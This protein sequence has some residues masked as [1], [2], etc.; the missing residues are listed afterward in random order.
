MTDVDLDK[1]FDEW[2]KKLEPHT[3]CCECTK[4]KHYQ[5]HVV[6]IQYPDCTCL[7]KHFVLKRNE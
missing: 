3:H 5:R 4:G 7:P 1:L 6:H 2:D